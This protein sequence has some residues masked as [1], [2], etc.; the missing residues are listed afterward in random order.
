MYAYNK[1]QVAIF[2]NIFKS[3]QKH[4]DAVLNILSKYE[5]SD[6]AST[7]VGVFVNPELQLTYNDLVS[8]VNISLTE[9]LKVG[10]TIED[11]DINDINAFISNT[12]KNDLL[13]VYGN[14]NC[15]S[16]NHIRSFT[17]ELTNNGITY[18]PQFISI[19]TYNS[20]LSSPN[21]SCGK[22]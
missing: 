1:Y 8:K 19:E 17:A 15:G 6:P 20:I 9:A 3:E 12:T 2:D 16:K 4:M 13:K 5:I 14:L 21:E 22:N 7:E 18:V 10:A 11:L